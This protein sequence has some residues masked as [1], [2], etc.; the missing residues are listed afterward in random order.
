VFIVRA[1]KAVFVAL[2]QAQAG[3]SV[4]VDF[5]PNTIVIT[6]HLALLKDQQAFEITTPDAE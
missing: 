4:A 3:Q 1:G 2:D 6:R 5:A